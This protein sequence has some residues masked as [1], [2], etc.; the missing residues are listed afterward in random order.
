M[1]TILCISKI[2]DPNAFTECVI[3]QYAH[4]LGLL[5]DRQQAWNTSI[6]ESQESRLGYNGED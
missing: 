3:V 6:F 2:Q 1:G 4:Q 5:L